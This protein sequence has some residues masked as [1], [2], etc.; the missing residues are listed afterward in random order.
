[1]EELAVPG[2]LDQLFD[3]L[4]GLHF[5]AKNREG[6]IM[7]L[8]R[9][10][11]LRYGL[12][13]DSSVVGLTDFDLNPH[14]MAESY[15]SD[16]E[17]IY[18]T[19]E[20]ITGRVELWWDA[21]GVPNWYVVTKQPLWSRGGT[22]VGVMGIIQDYEGHARLHVPW[23]EIAPAVRHI[24]RHFRG[25]VSMAALAGKA[26]LS[27]RQLQRKFRAVLRLTPQEFL[28]KTRVLAACRLLR[29]SDVPLATVAGQCGFYD[30]SS[31]TE[32]FRRH[33]GQ[34]PHAYRRQAADRQL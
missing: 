34:T 32:H 13:K 10:I 16:D 2:L 33:A 24:R 31:F 8:S 5:F 14:G 26:G 12:E 23:R 18:A 11:C 3:G 21:Q 20:P 30:Q 4:P 27:L 25:A 19:G 22:I 29:E 7:Y 17:R 6:R 28:I 15:V 9:S 1:M